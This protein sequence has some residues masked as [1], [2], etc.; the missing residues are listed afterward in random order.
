ME[1][2]ITSSN[3]KVTYSDIPLPTLSSTLSLIFMHTLQAMETLDSL[4]LS[5]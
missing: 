5:I 3:P 4:S 2:M 1:P